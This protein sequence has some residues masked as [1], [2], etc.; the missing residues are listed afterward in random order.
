MT[1]DRVVWLIIGFDV[2]DIFCHQRRLDALSRHI[3]IL[4]LITLFYMVFH[5]TL[6]SYNTNLENDRVG[7]G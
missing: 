1:C 4:P 7:W 5:V 3:N 2:W 6:N